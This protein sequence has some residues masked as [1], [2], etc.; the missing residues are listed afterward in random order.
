MPEQCPSA[1]RDAVYERTR[2]TDTKYVCII[3]HYAK[4]DKAQAAPGLKRVGEP[5]P[6]SP[7]SGRAQPL[8]DP[9]AYKRG[10][11]YY[12]GDGGHRILQGMDPAVG[13]AL[14]RL[15]PRSSGRPSSPKPGR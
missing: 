1:S 14:Q 3:E 13:S 12:P 4:E 9:L 8:P 10:Q 6:Q 2:T 5:L 7:R 15:W 11:D